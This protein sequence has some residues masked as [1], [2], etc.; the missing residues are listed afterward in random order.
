MNPD[1]E[2]VNPLGTPVS[3]ALRDV[4]D[5]NARCNHAGRPTVV[6]H[7]GHALGWLLSDEGEPV[8]VHVVR[9]SPGTQRYIQF[10][11]RTDLDP[12]SA[13][14]ADGHEREICRTW[15]ME[16]IGEGP[17][18]V[19]APRDHAGHG[20]IVEHIASGRDPALWRG[21]EHSVDNGTAEQ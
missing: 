7:E 1:Y 18:R 8:F 11:N 6:C 10:L 17:H 3:A 5:D 13:E 12:F 9:T 20:C 4:V 21:T 16:Q 2:G 19:V 15:L 14:C